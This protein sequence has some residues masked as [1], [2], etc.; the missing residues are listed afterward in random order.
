MISIILEA[1]NAILKKKRIN[2][3]RLKYLA[4]NSNYR[5]SDM[6][7]IRTLEELID[8]SNGIGPS[9]FAEKYRKK[10]TEYYKNFE[11]SA[12]CHDEFYSSYKKT[13]KE[14]RQA[15]K[16]FR[17]NCMIEVRKHKWGIYRIRLY[18]QARFLYKMVK[19]FGWKAFLE[20]KINEV[21]K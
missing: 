9:W 12:M 18:F 21:V 4:M 8:C 16:D 14:F 6:F 13:V 20:A 19:W 1:E 3:Q 17:Y 11:A 5:T 7:Y 2:I 15:N 10:A